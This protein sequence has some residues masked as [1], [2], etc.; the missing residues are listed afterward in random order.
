MTLVN[1]VGGLGSRLR[2]VRRNGVA[3]NGSGGA[4]SPPEIRRGAAFG[5]APSGLNHSFSSANNTAPLIR[6]RTM[7]PTRCIGLFILKTRHHVEA[8]YRAVLPPQRSFA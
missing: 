8:I 2:S 5:G 1:S 7:T 3:G 6:A 4:L